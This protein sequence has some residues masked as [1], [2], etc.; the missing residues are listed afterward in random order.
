MQNFSYPN[1][2][3]FISKENVY[4]GPITGRVLL[5]QEEEVGKRDPLEEIKGIEEQSPLVD[6]DI[7][8]EKSFDE[9]LSQASEDDNCIVPCTQEVPQFL[10]DSTHDLASDDVEVVPATQAMNESM[11]LNQTY[12]SVTLEESLAEIEVEDV[13]PFTEDL[14]ESLAEEEIRDASSSI[15]LLEESMAAVEVEPE[16]RMLAPCTQAMLE[17]SVI[18]NISHLDISSI[19][20]SQTSQASQ[21]SSTAE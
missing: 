15:A 20:C 21:I 12:T 3:G 2:T 16:S 17:E 11:N 13:Q 14:E 4:K 5:F 18:S 10:E 8:S 7:S 19:P 9:R 6:V 1:I